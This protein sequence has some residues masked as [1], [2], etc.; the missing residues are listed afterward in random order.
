MYTAYRFDQGAQIALE[1]ILSHP[2]NYEE[3][4]EFDA[5]C[6]AVVVALEKSKELVHFR[7]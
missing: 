7:L 5:W 6:D 2:E 4:E 3:D 1:Y